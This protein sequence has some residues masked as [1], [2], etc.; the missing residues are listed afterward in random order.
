[1]TIQEFWNQAFLASLHRLPPTEAKEAADQSL[2]LCLKHWD[3]KRTEWAPVWRHWHDQ[4]VSDY[5]KK[6]EGEAVTFL[7]EVDIR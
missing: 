1:M 4:Q 2:A 5:S 7:A 3:S 6:E